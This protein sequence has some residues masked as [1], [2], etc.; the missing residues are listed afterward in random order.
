MAKPFELYFVKPY[1]D[2]TNDISEVSSYLYLEGVCEELQSKLSSLREKT[3]IEQLEIKFLK[4]WHFD[5]RRCWILATYW[6]KQLP[7][8]VSQNAGRE[9]SDIC[10][11]FIT[12]ASLYSAFIKD[13]SYVLE[14][15][16]IPLASFTV[17]D[18]NKEI[19]GLDHFYGYN[20]SDYF[21][22]W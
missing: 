8:M 17:Y 13:L 18:E 6:Y 3:V 19:E 20:L 7:F 1:I 4:K 14:Q 5:E 2:K 9:G 12:N 16:Q 22:T 10:N 21:D 11:I 15:R